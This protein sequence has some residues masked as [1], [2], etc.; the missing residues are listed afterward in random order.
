VALFTLGFLRESHKLPSLSAFPLSI[1]VVDFNLDH[2][3]L[4]VDNIRHDV[5][6]SPAFVSATRKIISGLIERHAGLD[7]AKNVKRAAK[8]NWGKEVEAYKGLY[9]EMM[10]DALNKAKG[11][12][13]IQIQNLVQAAVLKMLLEEIKTQFDLLIGRLKKNA[14]TSDLATHNDLAEATILKEKVQRIGQAREEIRQR[15]G[16]EIC[17]MWGEVEIADIT[18]MREAIFGPRTPFF[19]ILLTNP[20]PHVEQ[21]ENEMFM[22]AEYDLALGRRVEDPDKYDRLLYYIRRLFNYLDLQ[23]PANHTTISVE[24]RNALP[25]LG[26]E[27]VPKEDQES[28]IRKIEGWIQQPGNIELLFNW[29]Q[30]KAELLE[31]KRHKAPSERTA[32]LVQRIKAQQ[33][34][35]AFFY[36]QFCRNGL[37]DRI[38][39]AYEMQPEYLE[40]CPPLTPHQIA[41]YLVMPKSR[42]ALK[43]RLKRMKSLYGRTF[44]L[45]PLNKKIKSMEQ[46][47]TAKR[48]AYLVRFLSAF[49]R[50]H[51][52]RRNCDLLRE[53][54]ERINLAVDEKII[55]LSRENNTL[56]EFLL[57][58]ERAEE[59]TPMINHVVIKAD[60]RGSTD[61]T[62]RMSERNL[63]P[64]SYFSLNF[65]DPI[66]EILADYDAHKVFIEGDAV[67]LAI[68]EHENTPGGWYSVARACGVAL[69]MLVIIQAI[70]AK[71]IKTNL[72]VLELGI[73]ISHSKRPPAFLFDGGQRIMI[74]PAINHADRLSSCSK[75]GR[76]LFADNKSP[77]NLFAFQLFSKEEAAVTADD[78]LT[79]YNVNGI[80]LSAE[81]FAKLREEIDLQPMAGVL[82][83]AADRKFKLY[84]GKFPTRSGRYQRLV[85]REAPVPVLDPNTLKPVQ[86]SSRHYYEVC[87]HPRLY[88]LAR[89]MG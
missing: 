21:S 66:S 74:S 9:K 20:L 6:L 54:M 26:E 71:N 40:Y 70:N 15:V 60:V 52:D 41:Q 51:R 69:N 57:S 38:T 46:M 36:R 47:T 62:F 55:S 79:R 58:H 59:K 75:Q 13:R 30:V 89:Q 17:A 56:Y 44:S 3:T 37:M 34:L 73:G 27:P 18:T 2:L 43:I 82:P 84:T 1:Y 48:K 53:A 8:V 83:E 4:G 33:D 67:I 45:A 81:G 78:L 25:T 24:Q 12:R 28:Y 29:Q 22:L 49:V 11:G 77:F 63:N 32:P 35:L 86:R 39:A 80:E 68:F 88:K 42:R 87:T 7:R 65:F 85:I 23:D 50:Y 72:P 76:L 61:I 5:L 19:A 16:L 10:R 31:L 64:A 14:R